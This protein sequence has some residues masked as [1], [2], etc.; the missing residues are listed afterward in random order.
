[1]QRSDKA[2]SI[3]VRRNISVILCNVNIGEQVTTIPSPFIENLIRQRIITRQCNYSLFDDPSSEN[4]SS[5]RRGLRVTRV[6]G[7]HA[8]GGCGCGARSGGFAAL[9]GI[10]D[11][12]SFGE[13]AK[14]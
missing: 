10:A 13:G 6:D 3:R 2:Q 12:L 9:S 1:M 11:A 14:T 8:G 4:S 5:K 7:G